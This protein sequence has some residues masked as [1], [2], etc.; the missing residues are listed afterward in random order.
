MLTG[1]CVRSL[2]LLIVE[3]K[4]LQIP[5][6]QNTL[7]Y[8]IVVQGFRAV[9]SWNH[10]K[11]DFH[12]NILNMLITSNSALKNKYVLIG[13]WNWNGIGKDL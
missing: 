12:Y 4:C 1:N 9:R 13:Y 7:S 10:F 3:I 11:F 8:V 6:V 2:K 5:T